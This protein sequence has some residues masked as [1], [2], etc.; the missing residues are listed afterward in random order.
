[1]RS[2]LIDLVS[3]ALLTAGGGGLLGIAARLLRERQQQQHQRELER[4]QQ[5]HQWKL[6]KQRQEHQRELENQRQ[7]IATQLLDNGADASF[8]ADGSLS[9]QRDEG[10]GEGSALDNAITEG[11]Q[12]I[13]LPRRHPQDDDP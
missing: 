13:L 12:I 11:G 8:G 10:S 1:M 4:Q 6:E 9:T 3:Y 5:E 2:S 7:R